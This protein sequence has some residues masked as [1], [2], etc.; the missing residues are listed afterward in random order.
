MCVESSEYR[1]GRSSSFSAAAPPGQPGRASV[2][3]GMPPRRQLPMLSSVV[4]GPG[5]DACKAD[6]PAAVRWGLG[7]KMRIAGKSVIDRSSKILQFVRKKYSTRI[8]C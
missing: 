3:A 1:T 8:K 6:P 5:C 2:D 4:I 7:A